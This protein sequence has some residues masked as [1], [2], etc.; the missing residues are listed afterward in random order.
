MQE[1]ETVVSICPLENARF[2][3]AL[4]NGT[5][6]TYERSNRNWRIKSRNIG[7]VLETF[8]I[9]GD[10]IDELVTGWSNG[11]VIS[12]FSFYSTKIKDICFVCLG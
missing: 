2:A 6:G 8:D 11:K 9:N 1:I 3:Y 5:I 4:S 7:I 12:R 10:G